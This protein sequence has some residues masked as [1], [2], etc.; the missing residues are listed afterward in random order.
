MLV[1]RARSGSGGAF[2]GVKVLVVWA[3]CA[4]EA[5][6]SLRGVAVTASGAVLVAEAAGDGFFRSGAEHCVGSAG[7]SGST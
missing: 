3:S 4:S 2:R 1:L 7:S 6:R 5:W